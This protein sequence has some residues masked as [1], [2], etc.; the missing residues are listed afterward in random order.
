MSTPPSTTRRSFAFPNPG[1]RLSAFAARLFPDDATALQQLLSWNLHLI[2][3]RSLT[4]EK[5]RSNDPTLLPTDIVYTEAPHARAN[6][7]AS[8]PTRP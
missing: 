5:T 8:Q 1:E 2:T 6:R 3:R 7:A 4:A